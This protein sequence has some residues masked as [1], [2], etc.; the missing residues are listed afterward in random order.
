[1]YYYPIEYS[2]IIYVY[3]IFILHFAYFKMIFGYNGKLPGNIY[4][5]KNL[6][7]SNYIAICNYI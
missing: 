2:G 5:V 7:L 6:N 3:L 1:M 4:L